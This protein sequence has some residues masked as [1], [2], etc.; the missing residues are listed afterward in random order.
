MPADV[1]DKALLK[2]LWKA[3]PIR[4]DGYCAWMSFCEAI[5]LI[6]DDDR[7]PG[8]GDGLGRQ[9]NQ[10]GWDSLLQLLEG[11]S[12]KMGEACADP[13]SPLSQHLLAAVE[14]EDV[15]EKVKRGRMMAKELM[16]SP[17]RP[18]SKTAPE[19]VWFTAEWGNIVSSVI[20]RPLIIVVRDDVS[21]HLTSRHTVSFHLHT[22]APL[23]G[24]DCIGG[25]L[26]RNHLMEV[27]RLLKGCSTPVC[28]EM[29]LAENHYQP[30]LEQG[31]H[32]SKLCLII[33]GS[34]VN[35]NHVV[36]LTEMKKKDGCRLPDNRP[37]P[38][39]E[40]PNLHEPKR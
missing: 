24:V 27:R 35:G 20:E 4:A 13:M 25:Q 38:W 23:E 1:W 40:R 9:W 28:V 26:V 22:P 30:Y 12:K 18:P 21:H 6:S 15:E 37:R 3:M 19:K 8:Q 29:S 33:I 39:H 5:G 10:Q 34:R 31:K 11:V 2:S 36:Q 17:K 16:R 14:G 7:V 32:P